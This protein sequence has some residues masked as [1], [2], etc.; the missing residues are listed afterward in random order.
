MINIYLFEQREDVGDERE[1]ALVEESGCD[2][3]PHHEMVAAV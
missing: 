1:S 2:D 3:L